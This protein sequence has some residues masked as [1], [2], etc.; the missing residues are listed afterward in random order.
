MP[1]GIK[2]HHRD[3]TSLHIG[4]EE[5]RA[6][7]VPFGRPTELFEKREASDRFTYFPLISY[8]SSSLT[9]LAL[10]IKL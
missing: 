1:F 3:L 8:S 6:Y 5:P 7:F 9:W 10:F 2:S 4:C